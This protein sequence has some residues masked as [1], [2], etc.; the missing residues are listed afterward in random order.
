M[1]D[2]SSPPAVSHRSPPLVP[3]V[4]DIQSGYEHL[5][6][7]ER[8]VRG[9]PVRLF[10]FPQGTQ[11]ESRTVVCLPGLGASGRS[12]APMGPLADELRLL[13]W[14]PPLRTPATHTPLQWNL[15]VLNHAEALLPERFALLG[16]SYGSL[17]SIAYTLA[18]PE[19]VKALVLI[20]PVASVRRIRRLALTLS[21]LVRSPRP[22][23]YVFAPTVARVLGGMYLPPEGRAEIVREARRLSSMELLRRLRDVLAADFLHRLHEIRVPTLVI[24]GGRD[25]L[26]PGWAARD[27]AERIPGARME[28]LRQA[29]HL[30]YMSHSQSFNS[31]VGDFLL[32][33]AV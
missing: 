20:S 11:D 1:L 12:F 33:H 13:L 4:E 5:L 21:T 25:L 17:L 24:Q 22:L 32:K 8:F 28:V 31:L 23:A 16:S 18:H 14:T 7:E 19:R 27:V 15:A 3:D 9:T 6:H 2:A 26:V 29:S 30:P 10:T